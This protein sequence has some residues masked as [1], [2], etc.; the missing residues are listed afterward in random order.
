LEQVDR[1]L[2]LLK[3]IRQQRLDRALEFRVRLLQIECRIIS[4]QF[5]SG[6]ESIRTALPLAQDTLE[7]QQ[8]ALA[9]AHLL[10][11]SGRSR[12]SLRRIRGVLRETDPVNESRA[13]ALW[14][15]GLACYR[16]GHYQWATRAFQRAGAYYR[17]VD[18]TK[19]LGHVLI[20]LSLVAKSVGKFAEAL[21]YLDEAA[22][23]VQPPHHKKTRLR[24]LVNRGIVLLKLG[25][26][27]G[28]RTC[29][30]EA[31][32]HASEKE[33]PVFSVMVNNNLGHIYRL[34][35]NHAVAEEFHKAA[36]ELATREES[37]RQQCLSLEFLGEVY[38]E[39]SRYGEALE[40]LERARSLARQLAG[41]GDLMMEV[42]RRR[43][44]AHVG[45]GQRK[46][47]YADLMRAAQMCD[48]RGEKREGA[49]ARRAIA[50]HF[51]R[52]AREFDESIARVLECLMRIGDQ[53]EYARTVCIALESKD[54]QR[55]RSTWFDTAVATATHY[56]SALQLGYWVARLQ[57]RTGTVAVRAVDVATQDTD[58]ISASTSYSLA[59]E[60]AK[61]A[62][63][64]DEPVLVQGETGTGKEV[65][66]G[67]IHRWSSRVSGPWIAINCGA[68]P[69]SLVESE[70]F[71]HVR[72]A[73]TGAEREKTGLLEAANQG[74]TLLLPTK[75][76]SYWTR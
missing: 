22:R 65:I 74:R 54:F 30:I 69:E 9:E 47:G 72:G 46:K 5:A 70:L 32:S 61:L 19:E 67:L 4:R 1:A 38:T 11:L 3:R 31:K 45:V 13:K 25:D 10:V 27:Q 76:L 26:I 52:S 2:T 64:S 44:E 15:V 68:L 59:L 42:L 35:N 14:I 8:L 21:A 6:L 49:L 62:A 75:G 48:A 20:N 63:R 36:L 40:C 43:G 29:L 23:L 58:L 50:I 53:F 66:A 51:A 34:E 24:L 16:N 7:Q 73:F 71:G 33:E 18:Q 28:S 56:F 17:L 12:D 55:P 41:H 37:Q 57:E 39:Q 60:S